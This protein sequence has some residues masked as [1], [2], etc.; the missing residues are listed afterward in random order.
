MKNNP[1]SHLSATSKSY[2]F[3]ISKSKDRSHFL[4]PKSL[5]VDPKI[6]LPA[7]S[8]FAIICSL[9]KNEHRRLAEF[10]GITQEKLEEYLIELIKFKYL[11]VSHVTPII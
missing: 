4:I 8:I 5:F 10:A 6:S 3:I 7:K 2:E 9:E 11:E 1:P